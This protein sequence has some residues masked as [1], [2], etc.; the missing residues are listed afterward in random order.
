MLQH[1]TAAGRD[2]LLSDAPHKA[3]L[4]LVLLCLRHTDNR[5]RDCPCH[6]M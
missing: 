1:N 2:N 3:T 5:G 4:S 6:P